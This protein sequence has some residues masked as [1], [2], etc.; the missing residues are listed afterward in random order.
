[1]SGGEGAYSEERL[2][3]HGRKDA[4]EDLDLDWDWGDALSKHCLIESNSVEL[5]ISILALVKG[6]IVVVRAS[7]IGTIL[8]RLLLV[9]GTSFIAGGYN[10]MEQEFWLCPPHSMWLAPQGHYGTWPRHR[11][12]PTF[13]YAS[14]LLFQLK[15][16]S[17]MYNEPSEVSPRGS[18]VEPAGRSLE[19][20]SASVS[21]GRLR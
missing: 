17:N 11:R 20:A 21:Q 1:M 8:G 10:R 9:F 14:Y 7:L 5:I 19:N 3:G 2:W 18:Q 12:H 6:E 16:H 13:V 15:A 4:K